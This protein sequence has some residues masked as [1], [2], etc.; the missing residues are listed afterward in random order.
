VRAILSV[1]IA[2]FFLCA[3]NAFAQSAQADTA[4]PAKPGRSLPKVFASVLPELK[5]KSRLP[6]LLPSELPDP[7]RNAKHA[8]LDKAA[9]DE[10]AISVYYELGVGE[11]GFAA[12][13]AADANSGYDPRKLPNVREVKLA[14]HVRGFFWPV[15]CG[16]SC[17]PA[18]V[19]WSESG[20]LYQ[21]QLQLPSTLHEDDQQRTLTAIADSAIV[22]GAR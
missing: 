10:Y 12:L 19:W 6:V 13:F 21:I 11:A 16:G 18:N 5:A 3:G 2:S 1:L 9:A 17:A 7:V 15:S 14:H 22:A 20:V 8:L 4:I